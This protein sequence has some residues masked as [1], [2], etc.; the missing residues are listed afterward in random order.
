MPKFNPKDQAFI[1]NTATKGRRPQSSGVVNKGLKGREIDA[2]D[3]NG[4]RRII[5]KNQSMSIQQELLR[6]AQRTLTGPVQLKN[7]VRERHEEKEVSE[8]STVALDFVELSTR[9]KKTVR[10]DETSIVV[11]KMDDEEEGPPPMF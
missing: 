9:I 5:R 8:K 4:V 2:Q 7:I 3:G 1:V 6:D 11:G 10:K